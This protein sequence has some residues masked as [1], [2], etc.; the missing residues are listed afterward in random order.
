MDCFCLRC[1]YS[2]S[3]AHY[4]I[5]L[6]A[7]SVARYCVHLPAVSA[8]QDLLP[9]SANPA[10][11]N[12]PHLPA[13]SAAQDLLHLPALRHLIHKFIQIPDLLRQRILYFFHTKPAD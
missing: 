6:P 12:V 9:L 2:V 10:A 11:Q 1:R 13:V 7:F 5:H 3:A 4:L 8:V